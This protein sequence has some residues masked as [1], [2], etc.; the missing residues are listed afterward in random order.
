M[1]DFVHRWE[2]GKGRVILALHGTGGDES[3]LVPI[4]KMLDPRAAV[5]A[6]R[7]RVLEGTMNRFFRRFEE[8]VFDLENMREETAAL[9]DFVVQKGLEH[10]FDPLDVYAL[11]F[12]NGANMAASLLL[13]RPDVL[14][15]AILL[16]AMV[17][18]EPSSPVDLN[19][20]RIFMV[21]GRVDPIIPL[22]NAQRLAAIFREAGADVKQVVLETGHNLTQGEI[23]LAREWLQSKSDQ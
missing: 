21:N 22:D 15:G 13:S 19:G 11:G 10:G 9:G 3:D 16:R 7:G 20:K 14:G 2:P 1:S 4:A 23:G 12:S 8:G 17:P 18:F 5:L 6:P